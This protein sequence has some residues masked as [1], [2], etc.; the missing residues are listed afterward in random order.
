MIQ[1]WQKVEI[2]ADK[3]SNEPNGQPISYDSPGHQLAKK[4]MIFTSVK[5]N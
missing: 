4:E 3:K 2:T 1:M 5:L